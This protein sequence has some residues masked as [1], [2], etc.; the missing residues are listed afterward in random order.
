[1]SQT[2]DNTLVTPAEIQWGTGPAIRRRPLW[3]SDQRRSLLD[4]VQA[5]EGLRVLPQE[6]RT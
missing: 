5:A 6:K 2:M 3:G 4:A 1:M